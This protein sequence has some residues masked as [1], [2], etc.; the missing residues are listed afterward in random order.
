MDEEAIHTLTT[1]EREVFQWLVRG[2]APVEV[3]EILGKSRQ[4]VRH[5][6]AAIYLKLAVFGHAQLASKYAG[7]QATATTP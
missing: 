4:T 1:K 5:Q 7:Y 2:K 6:A 3:A